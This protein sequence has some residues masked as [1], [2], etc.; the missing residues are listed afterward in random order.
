MQEIILPGKFPAVKKEAPTTPNIRLK[1]QRLRKQWSQVYVATRIGTN[2]VTVSRW[3]NGTTFPSLY[4]REKLCELF[5]KSAE[6][7]GLL[8]TTKETSQM[9]EDTSLICSTLW[10]V[11]YRRN[12]LF[13]G[14]E[15]ILEHL[16]TLLHSGNRVA[17]TQ[18]QA[19]SGLGGMGK[20]Q[21]AIEYAYRHREEYRAV[22]WCRAETGGALIADFVSIAEL[23]DLREKEDQ[24]QRLVVQAVRHWLQTHTDWLLILDNIEDLALID[25]VLPAESA[26]HLVLTTRT[27]VTGA[28]AQ[29]IDLGQMEP[30]ESA[31]FLLRR[32]KLLGL[33][34]RLGEAAPADR[35]TAM[36]IAHLLGSLPLAL[37]Q[38]GAYIEETG[39][40]LFDY[41]ERY[42]ARQAAL[43]NR[44]GNLVADHPE[45]VSTTLSLSFERVEQANPVAADLLRLY[46]FLDPDAIPEELLSEVDPKLSSILQPVSADPLILDEALAALRK[47]SLLHRNPATRT[48]TVHRLVQAVLKE[49]MGEQEQ[50]YWAERTVLAVNRVFPSGDD[51]TWSLCQRYLPHAE[52][53]VA[54]IDR[55][56]MVFAE[57]GRLLNQA[58][59]YLWGRAQYAQAE[60]LLCKA[61]D[62]RMQ[63]LGAQHSDVAET[64]NNLGVLYWDQARYTEAEPLFL[65]ALPIWEQE[66]GPQHPHTAICLGNLAYLYFD[67][68][69]YAEAEALYRRVLAIHEQQVGQ[70]HNM[71]YSLNGLGMLYLDLGR[72]TEAELFFRRALAIWEQHLG[73]EHRHTTESLQNLA[74]LYRIQRKYKKAEP[75]L[76]RVLAIREEKLGPEHPVTAQTLSNLGLLYVEQERYSEAEPL[77]QRALAIREQNIGVEHPRMAYSLN[78]L[79]LLYLNQERYTEAQP[80]LQRALMI[81]EEQLGPEHLYTA[82]S[83][84]NLARLYARQGRCAEAEPLYQRALRI[85]EQKLGPEHPHTI[86][87]RECY[88]DLLGNMKQE[89]NARSLLNHHA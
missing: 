73:P 24:D 13:T 18:V 78:N 30:Q 75:L 64:L 32:A 65:H 51:A 19:I 37:D 21:T 57:A 38:A 59:T 6:D 82:E 36:A 77:S 83:L 86:T 20:T 22:F 66:L 41:L 46:A 35:A 62:I 1:A 43:L 50:R 15:D 49:R 53:C 48:F 23:L 69:R 5:G 88:I 84:H 27:Q 2:D 29:R 9:E 11:P 44:R 85:R 87:T 33:D 76:L 14:R 55:W 70:E 34:A 17:L 54:L 4:Y 16:H 58:G 31:L 25:D 12:P 28:L 10:N 8:P 81:R 61:R 71:A 68:G 47:Y 26:G 72:Y 3:E 7:L 45:S 63:A 89:G 67:Q 74:R 79:G 39:C 52:A 40:S 60:A 56:E 80:L 42:R